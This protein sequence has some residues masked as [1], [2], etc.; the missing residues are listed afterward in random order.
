MAK[1]KSEIMAYKGPQV[2][3]GPSSSTDNTVPRFDLTSGA[4]IQG[5]SVVISDA[6]AVS[7]V[8]Q[9]DV[10]NVRINGNTISST[11]TNGNIILAPDGSGTVSVT[12]APIVPSGDRADSLG[13][14]TNSWDNVYADGITFDDGTNILANY[15]AKTSWT[16]GFEFSGGSTGLTISSQ[17]GSYTRIGDLCFFNAV[18]A[19]SAKGSSTGTAR[20]TNFPFTA[21]AP[22]GPCSIQFDNV[23]Y[24]LLRNTVGAVMVNGGTVMTFRNYGDNVAEGTIT[25]TSINNN[26]SI[27][28]RGFYWIA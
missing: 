3:V 14:A 21:A 6:D 1:G 28:V 19:L 12:A 10:D 26:T 22:F 23:T 27:R 11:D 16:P 18:V 5:S 25:D 20:M 7:G 13:S 2:V 15:V 17:S 4:L 24:Q 9:L 8:T